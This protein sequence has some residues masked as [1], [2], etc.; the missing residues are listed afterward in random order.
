MR[1]APLAAGVPLNELHDL[2]AHL[3]LDG[4][5]LAFHINAVLAA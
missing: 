5:E 1:S 2:I 4:A 3:R